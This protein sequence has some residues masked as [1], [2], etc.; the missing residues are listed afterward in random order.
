MASLKKPSVCPCG[1]CHL[2]KKSYPERWVCDSCG[3]V[4][5]SRKKK[6]D[7][8]VCRVCGIG[9]QEVEFKKNSNICKNCQSDYNRKYREDHYDSIRVKHRASYHQNKEKRKESVKK[10]IQRSPEAFIR[11]LLHHIRKNSNRQ[12]ARV[13]KLNQECLNVSVTYEYL[14]TLYHE[15]DG[16]CALSNLDMSHNFNDP[17]SISIDRID[18]GK[19]YEVGNV[20]LVC[21]AFNWMKNNMPQYQAKQL[22]DD[23]YIRRL[24][25]AR[26]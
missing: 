16:R 8:S 14:I 24:E 22:L 15:Q 23:Y 11:N 12:K 1:S 9:R 25:S 18:S 5:K 4:V 19:G 21:Q 2:I 7:T 3:E 20:Q 6:N 17:R 10:A 13:G 26:G